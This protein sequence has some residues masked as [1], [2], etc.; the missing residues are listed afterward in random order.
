MTL[1][2]TREQALAAMGQY[3][4]LARACSNW[5]GPPGERK[6]RERTATLLAACG[7]ANPAI[8]SSS[9][10]GAAS[11]PAS[12]A[13][14]SSP[15]PSPVRSKSGLSELEKREIRHRK[16]DREEARE[17]GEQ[18]GDPD[19]GGFKPGIHRTEWWKR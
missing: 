5:A 19:L 2:A 12:A 16:H 7:D 4:A 3:Q 14:A 1:Y 15:A 9:A 17:R 6:G 18:P 10:C 13:P 8:A 11:K